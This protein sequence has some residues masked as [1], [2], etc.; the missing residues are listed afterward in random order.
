MF[1]IGESKAGMAVGIPFSPWLVCFPKFL[2]L[3][4][5]CSS[6]QIVMY[7]LEDPYKL[8]ALR[9]SAVVIS[10]V[11]VVELSLGLVVGSLA[12]ISDGLHAMFDAISTFF[13]FYA[14]RASLRP[15]D[16]E[17][18]YGHE[19]FESIGGLVGGLALIGI[20]MLIFAEAV[21]RIAANQPYINVEFEYAGYVAIGY[22]FI[23]DFVR[24]VTFRKAV[25]TES[26]TLKAGL[27]H[28]VADLSS[29]L[30]ALAGFVLA[31]LARVYNGDAF[32]S[33]ILS[34]ILSYLSIKLAWS[35]GMELSDRIS[36]NVAEKVRKTILE[37]RGVYRLKSLKVRKSGQK[38]LGEASLLVSDCMNL[39]EAHSLASRVEDN[40]RRAV[41]Y[42]EITVH[43][44]PTEAELRTGKVVENLAK[45]VEGVKDAHEI[46]VVCSNGRLYISLHARVDPSLSVEE[47]HRIAEEIED[48]I[49][50]EVK[51]VEDVTVHMEPYT[52][53]VRRGVAVADREIRG[54]I[55]R[56]ADQHPKVFRIK[57][58]VT[59]VADEKRYINIDCC[60]TQQISIEEAHVIASQI[61]NEVREHFEETIVTVHM[62]P[63]APCS[64]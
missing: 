41:K 18:M 22:T 29:T 12:I 54:I 53:A 21:G 59:F 56:I 3:A 19:K 48:K 37:T 16:E 57:G 42:A 10:S 7:P 30:V 40:V 60:F 51:D 23:V 25:R 47:A 46:N 35:S 1:Q 49:I 43:L 58:M 45:Q 24:V 2:N 31:T 33:I 6:K 4:L 61:E 8:R 38:I 55:H 62:E 15:P 32:A 9:L 14:T 36:R 64:P 52:Y 39:E 28:S 63:E 5:E 50:R 11:V 13:L 44:E 26:S 20:A 34:V 17:H 27:Y